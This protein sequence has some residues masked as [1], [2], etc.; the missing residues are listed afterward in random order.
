MC[1]VSL[2]LLL[3]PSQQRVCSRGRQCRN[4]ATPEE[5]EN[6]KVPPVEAVQPSVQTSAAN[7]Q[8]DMLTE[9]T[10]CPEP[11]LG[12]YVTSLFLLMLLDFLCFF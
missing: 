1:E 12:L 8:R 6:F 10:L 5:E 2:K 3:L 11:G 4:P 9:I 7:G